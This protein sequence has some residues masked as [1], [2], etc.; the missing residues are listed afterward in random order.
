[1]TRTLQVLVVDDDFRVADL[2]AA[3]VEAAPGFTVAGT[4]RTVT[5]ARVFL[6]ERPVDL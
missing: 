3:A 4:A 6:A 2:H 5:E 1:M